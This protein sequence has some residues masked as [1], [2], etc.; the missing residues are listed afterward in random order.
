[1]KAVDVEKLI[2]SHLVD[3]QVYEPV[4]PPELLAERAGVP[5]SEIVKLNGNENP[6]GGSQKAVEAVAKAPLHIYPDPF[7]R[8]MR[9]ALGDYTGLDPERIIAGAGSDELIDLLFRLFISPGDKIIDCDPT[10]AMYAFCA[11][12]AGG[13]I[14][15][16]PRDERFEIDVHAVK[17][18][19][20]SKS[21]IIFLSSP[22]NPTGNLAAEAQVRELLE[23]GLVVVV[24][25]AYHE[26]CGRSVAHLVP[27]HENLVVLRTMS[28]WAGLAGLRVG[29]GLMSPRLVG[30]IMDI[31]P[32]YNVNVAAEAALLASLEDAPALLEN[33]KA[34]AHERQRMFSLLEG[35][36]GVRPWPSFGN[37]ILCQLASGAA[38]RVYEGLAMRGVFVRRF[39]SHRLRDCLRVSVGRPDQTDAFIAALRELA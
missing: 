19:V 7:Q 30:H 22:N 5:P 8:R 32:P 1:M 21:K 24:D 4:D 13:C 20:D 10:F 9:S 2:R 25:E 11:R 29:Y 17:K 34:I 27:E 3:I 6:Y 16:V 33:V 18:A 35:L 15:M 37:F 23:T 36:P 39:S 14:Q 38:S 12:V 31:K 28:K 26:F